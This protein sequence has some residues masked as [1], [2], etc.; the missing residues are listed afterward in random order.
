MEEII[1]DARTQLMT[2]RSLLNCAATAINNQPMRGNDDF[3]YA[4]VME[5]ASTIISGT[6]ERLDSA[7][8]R[9]FY[10]PLERGSQS[11][12][13]PIPKPAPANLTFR[14]HGHPHPFL[15]VDPSITSCAEL[16]HG[17]GLRTPWGRL[18]LG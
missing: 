7:N 10:D 8:L 6:T 14:V 12:A 3:I 2:A 13:P 11:S 16:R 5:V 1:E 9:A 4:D 18:W 17:L 15:T